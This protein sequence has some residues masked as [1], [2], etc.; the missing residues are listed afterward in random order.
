MVVYVVRIELYDNE[1]GY[2]ELEQDLYNNLYNND[3]VV[4]VELLEVYE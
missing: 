2:E 1:I 4:D 3:K